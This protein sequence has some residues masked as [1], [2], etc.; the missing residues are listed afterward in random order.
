MMD[1]LESID[2]DPSLLAHHAAAAGD[3][4]RILRYAPVAAAESSRSGSHREAVAFY[5]TALRNVGNDPAARAKL[6]ERLSRELYLTD[7]LQD[8]IATRELALKL[9]RET[10]EVVAVG[11][12]HSAISNFAWYAADRALAERHDTAAIEI[13]SAADARRPF[14]FALAG[15]A[16]LAIQAG[17]TVEA[18]RSG[19]QA[20]RIADELGDDAVLRATASVGIAVARL[21][22]G[23]L[24]G[25]A[26]LIAATDVGLRYRLDELATTPMSNLC[27]LDVEQG[28]F[29]DAEESLAQA[30]QISTER[31]TP[32]C[33]AWQLGV[34]ARLRLLQGRWAEAEKDARDVLRSGDLPLS[35][36]W[37]HLV[38][39]LLL[40]RRE[41]PA[42]NQHLDELWPLVNRLDNPGN[43]AHAAAALAENAWITRNP[44][45][46]LDEPL[47]HDLFTRPYAGRDNAVRPLARWSRRLAEAGIQQ[48]GPTS[49]DHLP[50]PADQPYERAMGL[51]DAGSTADLLAALP[52]LDAFDARAVAA[53]FRA[54]LR[55][56]GVSAVPRGSSPATRANPAGLTARQLDVLALLSDGLSNADIAARLVIS[57]KTADHH[58]SAILAKMDVSNRR[59]AA[60][61]ARRLVFK[62]T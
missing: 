10:G 17:D 14:G 39:G 37:P 13:L 20:Y 7:R 40:S 52:V 34:R 22:D 55:S 38:L 28:R 57:R 59:E 48:V 26:D 41:A 32:I 4:A 2:A 45:P 42:A 46:R 33:S 58:V 1:A 43:V 50:A 44:D 24:G 5:E 16:L 11:T 30:L 19:D 53:L 36:L 18:H 25:R 54:R 35:Q 56:A 15:H 8:A 9:R 27:H 60:A 6:L 51:W 47:I 62:T 21:L 23:D 49:L 3:V 31:D 12:G 61:A 29:A